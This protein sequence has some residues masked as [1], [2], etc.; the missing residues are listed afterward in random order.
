MCTK[1]T[2]WFHDLQSTDW[3]LDSYQQLITIDC[4]QDYQ[5]VMSNLIDVTNGIYCFM[6]Q[7]VPPVWEHPLNKHGSAW[8]FKV[9]KKHLKEIW[10]YLTSLLFNE[11]ICTSQEACQHIL[12][13]SISPK[14]HNA[15]VRIWNANTSND[16]SQFAHIDKKFLDFSTARH[17]LN[18]RL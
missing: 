11:N 13:V 15:T 10:L 17:V 8:T 7:G 9:E 18:C 12:G 1:W 2:L 3:S 16:I 14:I 6:R 5:I 4:R